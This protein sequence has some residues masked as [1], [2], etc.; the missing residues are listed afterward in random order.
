MIHA[1]YLYCFASVF[2]IWHHNGGIY[3]PSLDDYSA[4]AGTYLIWHSFW[5]IFDAI[6]LIPESS[7]SAFSLQ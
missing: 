4:A 5:S 6:T 3:S 1:L 2:K 7:Q